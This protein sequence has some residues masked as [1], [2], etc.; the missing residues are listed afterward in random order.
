MTAGFSLGELAA[1]TYS[2]AV[3][4]RTGFKL[5]CR[6]GALMQKASEESDAAMVAVLRLKDV[7]VIS[8][9]GEFKHVY[10]VNFNCPGQTVVAGDRNELEYFK[11][12]AK[13]LGGRT[14]PL[15][16]CGAFHSPYM[17]QA[18][19]QFAA[20]LKGYAISRRYPA[21]FQYHRAALFRRF[22]V[23]SFGADLRP[24][25]LEADHRQ[26]DRSRRGHLY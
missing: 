20:S 10:P 18:A 6:R 23:P 12:C 19:F 7:D 17:E 16:V 1:L 25:A 22:Q 13:E 8:L 15:N 9:C 24:R 2:G 3:D 11:L 14:M 5:V 26:Y 4:D 21:L